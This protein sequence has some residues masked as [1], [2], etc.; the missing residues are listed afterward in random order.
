[1]AL[2]DRK[3]KKEDGVDGENDDE[4]DLEDYYDEEYD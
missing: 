4:Y 3:K 2:G 1:V